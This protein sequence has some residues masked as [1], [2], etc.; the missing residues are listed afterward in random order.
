MRA[1]AEARG[2]PYL[3]DLTV[4]A[5]HDGTRGS[6]AMR[7]TEDE[8]AALY[9]GPLRDLI[10]NGRRAV[11]E[12]AFPCNCARGNCAISARGDVFP[13]VSVP[14]AAG[15]VREQPFGEIWRSS[16]VFQRIRGLQDRRLRRPAPP[17]PTRRSARAIAAPPSTPR[18]ATPGP[19][20]SSAPPPAS[21]GP[22]P[23]D[24]GDS[25]AAP[26]SACRWRVA[27]R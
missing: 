9:R 5:R 8:L 4:T 11:D 1:L 23:S 24:D 18:A 22:S 26:T 10:P 7:I 6:L 15:N 17:A 19:T 21:R 20:R 27:A 2:F 14:W 13:C 3:V 12:A 25:A 16:P